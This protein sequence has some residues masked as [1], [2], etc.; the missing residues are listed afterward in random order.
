MIIK[1]TKLSNKLFVVFKD[2]FQKFV[3][4]VGFFTLIISLLVITYY[5]TSGMSKRFPPLNL[6]KSI[7]RVILDRYLGFSLF[8]ID[9]YFVLKI[10]S[11]KHFFTLDKLEEVKIIIDQ[12]NLYNLE[13]QRKKKIEN[14]QDENKLKLFS[15]AKINIKDKSIPIKLRVKGDRLLHW[16]DKENTSYKIDIQGSERAWGLEEFAVQKPITRNYIYEY[17]FHKLLETNNLISLKYFFINLSINDTNQGVYAI[18]EGFSKELIE[19]NKKRN[20]PIFGVDEVA[21]DGSGGGITYPF[22]KYDLYSKKFWISNYPK[23]TSHAI[24]KLNNL[25]ENNIET[26]NVFDLKEWAKYFAVIDL[27]NAIHGIITKSVK[28]YYNPSTGKFEP[29]GFDGHY[30]TNNIQ[31]FLLLDFLDINNKNCGYICHEREWIFKFFKKNNGELNEEFIQLYTDALRKITSEKFIEKFKNDNLDKINFYN[32]HLYSDGSRTDRGLFKGAGYYIYNKN[33][34][35]DRANYIKNRLKNLEEIGF[36]EASLINGKIK[37]D[38]VGHFFLKKLDKVCDENVI[39]SEFI[40]K[41]IEIDFNKGCKYFIGKKKLNLFNNINLSKDLSY[42]IESESLD[43]SNLVGIKKINNDYYLTKDISIK[44]NYIFPKNKK[45]II[46]PGVKINFEED[47]VFVSEGA[48]EFQGA[49]DNPIKIYSKN[50]VGS[51]ILNN[52]DYML[53]HVILENLSYPKNKTKIL[54]GG[55]NIIN[56]NVTILNTTIKKSNSEDAINIID[57]KSFINNLKLENIKADAI[58]IDF[59]KVE[60]GTIDCENIL[61]DCFDVSGAHVNGKILN[62]KNIYDKGISFGENSKGIIE[63]ANLD[64]N[65]LGIAVKDQSSLEINKKN[66]KDNNI[67]IAVFNKKKSYAGAIFKL[68]NANNPEQL[69]V[70]VGENNELI[71]NLKLQK[72]TV[73][74]SFINSILY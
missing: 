15:F 64:N 2:L 44:E 41:N 39:S 67:D 66:S 30:G 29:I 42:D 74:N 60:F 63:I 34:L 10:N 3:Y 24:A 58:D 73:K 62:A 31:N 32:S 49:Q 19:R 18:E 16:Y 51:I 8:E 17:I 1:K 35:S 68:H 47:K 33:Y 37:F 50:K 9:D 71:T 53:D 52:N 55:L 14:I 23:M 61:N 22:I 36:L 28:L 48:I 4:I 46:K 65:K 13:L 21:S 69:K 6:I 27:T 20:G 54:Y 59:G 7:D 45:L 12:K 25:K 70:Y 11:I 43:F 26:A 56:S 38:N 72:K 57:S 5:T 40:F